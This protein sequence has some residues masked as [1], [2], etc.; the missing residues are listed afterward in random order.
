MNL[1]DERKAL[2]EY[3]EVIDVTEITKYDEETLRV[4][5]DFLDGAARLVTEEWEWTAEGERFWNV[6][7]DFFWKL[8]HTAKE[9]L[10]EF[11]FH[12][13]PKMKGD[14]KVWILYFHV[15]DFLR[16]SPEDVQEIDW[17][18]DGSTFASQ[19]DPIYH[20]REVLPNLNGYPFASEV[21]ETSAE[22]DFPVN[23]AQKAA[24]LGI[25]E[26]SDCL[27]VSEWRWKADGQSLWNYPSETCLHLWWVNPEMLRRSGFYLFSECDGNEK[28]CILYFNITDKVR[29]YVLS[30]TPEAS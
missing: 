20:R 8:W 25:L 22:R 7:S 23:D 4:V 15:E 24:I 14:R 26:S 13:H 16:L 29:A 6:P 21:Q 28:A 1:S 18:L 12:P 10:H 17:D 30:V 11:G 3:V 2:E 9:K 19:E 27:V 5:S